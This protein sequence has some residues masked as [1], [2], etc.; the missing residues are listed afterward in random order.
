MTVDQY[1]KSVKT[2]GDVMGLAKQL[3]KMDLSE[4][5]VNMMV[6]SARTQLMMVDRKEYDRYIAYVGCHKG[7]DEDYGCMKYEI[8]CNHGGTIKI[9]D[10]IGVDNT[11]SLATIHVSNG[12]GL[13][14]SR[15]IDNLKDIEKE[16]DHAKNTTWIDAQERE[17]LIGALENLKR[18][19]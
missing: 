16:I 13:G 6:A 19:L 10:W 1:I 4:N 18:G 12:W 7:I 2:V 17:F 15:Y 5:M 3:K 14:G 8:N 11:S 9:S